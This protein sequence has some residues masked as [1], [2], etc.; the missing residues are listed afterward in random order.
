MMEPFEVQR[1][2][3]IAAPPSTVFRYFTDSARFAAW[4]GPGSTIEPREGGPVR[5]CYPGG[6]VASGVVLELV[7]DRR[8]RFSYGY[9]NPSKPIRPGGSVV[10]IELSPVAGGTELT[11][12]HLVDSEAIRDA[13][14]PGWRYQL[15]VFAHVVAKEQHAEATARVDRYFSA[16]AEPDPA[17]RATILAEATSDDVSFRDPHGATLGRAEL[18]DHIGAARLHLGALVLSR[19]GP[20]RQGDDLGVVSWVAR[21]ASGKAAAQGE[22]LLCFAPDGKI[23]R[24][25]GVWAAQG[26]S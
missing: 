1:R 12:Q 19:Q 17:T 4:W 6:E 24:I 25:V 21:D 14:V 23:R 26:T 7:P 15:A 5:I 16:W 8:L 11:L 10:L 13:H 9:E 3:V 2:L 22:N 20:V 18:V